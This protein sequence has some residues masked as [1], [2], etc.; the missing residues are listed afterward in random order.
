MLILLV[1]ALVACT[2]NTSV[3]SDND[4]TQIIWRDNTQP[5]LD[6]AD[7]VTQEAIKPPS[8]PLCCDDLPAL[9]K[10]LL[11][12]ASYIK[13]RCNSLK[14]SFEMIIQDLTQNGSDPEIEEIIQLH[15]GIIRSYQ[16]VLSAL[17]AS[18]DEIVERPQEDLM[19]ECKVLHLIKRRIKEIWVVIEY[20]RE[21][22]TDPYESCLK[23]AQETYCHD[24]IRQLL[25]MIEP[26][27]LKPTSNI[28]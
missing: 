14:N 27:Q 10:Q 7:E 6:L 16:S 15:F 21:I 26:L 25:R 18:V 24:K 2:S 11:F 22:F 13:L 5:T 23:V 3:L 19:E 28:S 17:R 4:R 12:D 8:E 1:A 9:V 20:R